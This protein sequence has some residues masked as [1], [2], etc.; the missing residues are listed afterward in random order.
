MIAPHAMRFALKNPHRRRGAAMLVTMLVTTA[1]VAVL[2][3]ASERTQ[4]RR[5]LASLDDDRLRASLAAE[6]V[7]AMVEAKLATQAAEI[8]KLS[9]NTWE[10]AARWWNLVGHSYTNGGS[11][12]IPTRA[13]HMNG[14]AIR[15]RIE[16]VRI[17]SVVGPD[18]AASASTY[19]VNHEADR[20]RETE[21][22][23]EA[24]STAGNGS[25]LAGNPPFYHYRVVTEA[26]ALRDQKD[27]TAVPWNEAGHHTVSVQVQRVFQ[28][29]RVKLFDYAIFFAATGE[30]G[31][32]EYE[33]EFNSTV[34]ASMHSNGAIYFGGSGADH[35]SKNYKKSASDGGNIT[36][37]STQQNAQ[38]TGVTGVFRM[39]K[40]ANVLFASAA[41]NDEP[42]VRSPMQVPR[43]GK[44]V[45]QSKH[46]TQLSGNLDLNGGDGN[47]ANEKVSL[48]GEKLTF[49]RDSR[50]DWSLP[51]NRLDP[52]ILDAR[53]GASPIATMANLPDFGGYP[54]ESQRSV[55][56]QIPLYQVRANNTYTIHPDLKPCDALYYTASGAITTTS[57][58]DTRVVYATEMPLFTFMNANG[59]PYEDVW[60]HQPISATAATLSPTGNG[61]ALDL[62]IGNSPMDTRHT[63]LPVLAA[64]GQAGATLG[65]HLQRSLYG[66]RNATTT[67]L[68]I[69]ERGR[70][71][72][73]F[74]WA[75]GMETPANA[76]GVVTAALPTLAAF[77]N[78]RA[79]FIRAYI[80]WLKSNYVVYLGKDAAG[81]P[82]DITDLFFAYNATAAEAT[83]D[84]ALLVASQGQ[85]LDRREAHW[86]QDNG[87]FKAN[88]AVAGDGPASAREVRAQPLTLHLGQVCAFLRNTNAD[89]G[90]IP[91]TWFNGM[92]YLHR[93][94]RISEVVGQTDSF[95]VLAPLRY[96][97]IANPSPFAPPAICNDRC[98]FLVIGTTAENATPAIGSPGTW[99]TYPLHLP[100]RIAQASNIN[101]GAPTVERNGLTIVTPNP[102]YV[103]GSFNTTNDS[104]GKL[105]PCAIFA[106]ALTVLSNNWKD[107]DNNQDADY[108]GPLP[109]ATATV[110]NASLV[111]NNLP[112]DADNVESG[113]SGGI[114]HLVRYLENWKNR[115]INVRGSM[116]VL[117]RMR[118]SRSELG[119]DTYFETPNR[120]F[121]F[122]PSIYGLT[123]TPPFAPSGVKVTRMVTTLADGP[124]SLE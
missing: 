2:F 107:A 105:P 33:P 82:R 67:G 110:I 84:V 54:F 123:R 44:P 76:T 111:L 117:N 15:W 55:G 124:H 45:K 6:S 83:G 106:D 37:G 94:P 18:A 85:F 100:V 29:Q 70:Q 52:Y 30:T 118:Y 16:P 98:P 56:S 97:P 20:L 14:C 96:H 68:T 48:N 7:A 115:N 102:C 79:G 53:S 109:T 114:H 112:T 74:R 104:T 78:N 26:Y 90:V 77:P 10:N 113:G 101:W 41:G 73:A 3:M 93:T 28:V 64:P 60:P 63:A 87:Y 42:S 69:R 11:V 99:V 4:G 9:L 8:E 40:I 43:P 47:E 75:Q 119:K 1:I 122:D 27:T 13:L 103:L 46:G 23:S 31:D 81:N 62:P 59:Q 49:N 22:E 80:A 86:L 88:D 91:A 116:V 58:T 92:I 65:Y 39:R 25:L 36:F 19:S 121:Q 21:R 17:T 71:N 12:I 72:G 32:I 50:S 108:D 5:A 34:N 24:R 57:G 95:N 120:N 35:K 38:I 66:E 61:P 89:L 51:E